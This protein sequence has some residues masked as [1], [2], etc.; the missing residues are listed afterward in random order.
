MLCSDDLVR[1]LGKQGRLTTIT[2]RGSWLIGEI[3]TFLAKVGGLFLLLCAV[4][5][6]YDVV[7]R[8]LFHNPTTWVAEFSQLLLFGGVFLTLAYG[9]KEGSHVDVRILLNILPQAFQAR[10]AVF[11]HFLVLI[12][13]GVLLR[14]GFVFLW[15]SYKLAERSDF[16]LFP[17]WS[18]KFVICLGIF[19]LT[20]QAL[21]L[22]LRK[23][24]EAFRFTRSEDRSW[25][26]SFGVVAIFI[27]AT[28]VYIL[29]H[30]YGNSVIALILL[31]GVLLL[32]GIPIGLSLLAVSLQGL[33]GIMGVERALDI[34]PQIVVN[35]WNSFTIMALPLF[36]FVG[37]LMYRS[38]LSDELFEFCKAW[39]GHWRGG[40][41]VATLAACAIFAA[42]SGSSVANAATIG[43]VAIPALVS[44]GHT[45]RFA[46]GLVAG[47]GTMGVLI[48]PSTA[49]IILGILMDQ[50]IGKLFIAGVCPG[51]LLFILLSITAV[52]VVRRS[53]QVRP[54][55]K[56]SWSDR[57]RY[58]KR[59]TPTL[60]MP[61]IILGGIYTGVFT[62]TEA[63]AIAAVYALALAVIFKRTKL[64][65]LFQ[66]LG[67][68]T[69]T[70]AMTTLLLG[71]AMALSKI[72]VLLHVTD[73]MADFIVNSGWSPWAVMGG[74][75]ISLLV[76]GCFLDG[77]AMAVLTIPIFAP[78]IVAMGFDPI[79]FAVLFVINSE[80][81]LL[82]PPVG[83]NLF[84]I[85]QIGKIE[86]DD[87]VRGTLP[88]IL[89]LLVCLILVILFPWLA[90]WMPGA[91]K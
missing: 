14:Y 88:F 17:M 21:V 4:L 10:L 12:I 51:I 84:V 22:F 42:I 71:A 18:I 28:A 30:A 65:F 36:I 78:V 33:I 62:P 77:S 59:A 44:A 91:M 63:A 25:L 9:L 64:R 32:S 1:G 34:A 82:T 6:T 8:Y 70:V 55:P 7:A 90:T 52:L 5:I 74:F 79:W 41:A 89:A 26:Q 15:K 85:Q 49:F 23:T 73:Q 46:G 35:T 11:S 3:S 72:V 75:Q 31:L 24:A 13:S 27:A 37:H 60:I 61:L 29:L 20:I 87:L 43:L 83:M 68:S 56:A 66:I 67:E 57:W 47:G 38:G 16:L 80:V 86:L 81:G 45:L 40:L 69:K 53:S 54:I 19:V 2:A 48:P 39:I 58:T 76:L 50:S